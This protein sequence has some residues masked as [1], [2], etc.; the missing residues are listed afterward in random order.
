[1]PT[2]TSHR[3]TIALI[4]DVLFDFCRQGRIFF[5]LEVTNEVK[6]RAA[7]MN[8]AVPARHSE[9]APV[10]DDLL[11]GGH[12]SGYESVPVPVLNGA[13]TARLYQPVGTSAE[14]TRSHHNRQVDP[15]PRIVLPAA[16]LPGAPA[17]A[18]AASAG[19]NPLDAT[20]LLL[21]GH[22]LPPG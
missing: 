14:V 6:R 2:R 7:A 8:P 21:A 12:M 4:T 17:P 20:V 13:Q 18:P 5:A 19:V 22:L 1:M 10:L 16:L 11:Q 9:M 3:E 15:L